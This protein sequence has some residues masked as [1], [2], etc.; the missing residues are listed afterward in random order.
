LTALHVLQRFNQALNDPHPATPRSDQG[1]FPS[2]GSGLASW[3][4]Q[5]R[6]RPASLPMLPFAT[7]DF[8]DPNA[9]PSFHKHELTLPKELASH[10]QFNSRLRGQSDMHL[11][12]VALQVLLAHLAGTPDLVIGM[13]RTLGNK[14]DIMPRRFKFSLADSPEEV[15][16]KT[17]ATLYASRAFA[18]VRIPSLLS[19]LNVSK[20]SSLH[21]VTFDWLA[22]STRSVK[23]DAVF[24]QCAQDLV[25]IVHEDDV[26]V[27]RVH[28]SLHTDLYSEE[29]AKKLAILYVQV[30]S[31]PAMDEF[32]TIGHIDFLSPEVREK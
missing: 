3:E 7:Q 23:D 11:G 10:I 32:E 8:R 19:A 29:D 18:H 17:K 16:R 26:N 28:V 6:D 12:L 21:Q 15:F 20:Q 1:M 2:R 4:A 14:S 22:N 5:L 25:V 13:G 30:L 24:F 27:L 9:S 31:A